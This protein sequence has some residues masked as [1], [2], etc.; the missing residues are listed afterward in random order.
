M[1]IAKFKSLPLSPGLKPPSD[2]FSGVL[3]R[4]SLTAPCGT[5]KVIV[6]GWIMLTGKADSYTLRIQGDESFSVEICPN[7][8]RPDVASKLGATPMAGDTVFKG[9]HAE[10]P[11]FQH[12]RIFVR[13]GE[14]E[15]FWKFLEAGQ[16]DLDLQDALRRQLAGNSA[17][18]VSDEACSYWS[19][20]DSA[21]KRACID[22]EHESVILLDESGIERCAKMT[23]EERRVFS[24]FSQFVASAGFFSDLIGNA[25]DGRPAEIPAPFS[26]GKARLVGSFFNG[27]N[28]L[29]F[30]G[31][32]FRFYIGQYIHTA[33]FVYFPDRSL[34]FRPVNSHYDHQHLKKLISSVLDCPEAFQRA[35][36]GQGKVEA[37]LIN[38]ISPYHFFYDCMPALDVARKKSRLPKG[39]RFYSLNGSCYFPLESFFN[40]ES[41]LHNEAVNYAEWNQISGSSSAPLSV[42]AGVSYRALT[43]ADLESLDSFLIA[44]AGAAVKGGNVERVL[45]GLDGRFPVVWIGI[46]AQKRSWINQEKA[47]LS[48]IDTLFEIYPNLA[49]VFDGMTSNIFGERT[50]DAQFSADRE[51]VARLTRA[52][53]E[54]IR[55]FDLVG[56]GSPEKIRICEAVDF[57]VANYSTG[58]MYPSRFHQLPGVAHLSKHLFDAV[59]DIHIHYDAE[60]VSFEHVTDFPDPECPRLD[61]VS[62]EVDELALVSL[63]KRAII[64]K[65]RSVGI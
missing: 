48:V 17:E 42:L 31:N 46:S 60:I 20:S 22:F 5:D 2:F 51:I 65:T 41:G 3:D 7:T 21:L 18:A 45:S 47:L 54:A 61:F 26:A 38:G 56:M 25:P 1:K 29:L 4:P 35:E 13:I 62:Y 52:L 15:I 55:I 33:D 49:V 24:I 39:V 16:I 19:L 59:K 27:I 14:E 23:S 12:L 40:E 58:S 10:I 34:C 11:Y 9:F 53:P 37:V 50:S 43:Q 63:V 32:G 64:E 30:E 28:F 57:F 36:S 6:S 44:R 8:P